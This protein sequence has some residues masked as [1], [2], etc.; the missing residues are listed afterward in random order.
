[1]SFPG[2]QFSELSA[3]EFDLRR[4]VANCKC[5]KC[6]G[7][8][9]HSELYYVPS[10]GLVCRACTELVQKNREKKEGNR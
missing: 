1:M 9:S 7:E 3:R 8:K 2:V 4:C 6:D 5:S 10:L